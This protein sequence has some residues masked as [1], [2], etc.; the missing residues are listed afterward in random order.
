MTGLEILSEVRARLADNEDLSFSEDDILLF[1]NDAQQDFAQTGCC[2]TRETKTSVYGAITTAV[3]DRLLEVLRV[4]YNG[5]WLPFTPLTD[6][7]TRLGTEVYT[8]PT[9]WTLWGSQVIV[10]SSVASPVVI[11]YT[12]IPDRLSGLQEALLIPSA[13]R[14]ALTAYIEWRCRKQNDDPLAHQA[15]AEYQAVKQTASQLMS[16]RFMG[17]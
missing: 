1:L 12:Y 4:E 5:N 3:Q 16:K 11:W 2:Q 13:W 7:T 8:L 10:N 15:L 9:A 14:A 17:I 6:P